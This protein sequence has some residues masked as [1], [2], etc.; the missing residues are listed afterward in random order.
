MRASSNQAQSGTCRSE[1]CGTV[2]S[3]DPPLGSFAPIGW[4]RRLSILAAG[5]SLPPPSHSFEQWHLEVAPR[6]QWRDRAGIAPDFLREPSIQLLG[7]N[8][9]HR[10][11]T[12]L[13]R[14]SSLTDPPCPYIPYP[15]F[16]FLC[17]P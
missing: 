10:R 6:S 12:P 11:P 2:A 9:Y 8:V 15:D 4:R 14:C 5:S 17:R 13:N 3:I 1:I 7:V 16:R